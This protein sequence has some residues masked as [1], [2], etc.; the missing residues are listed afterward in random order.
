M[1]GDGIKD[2]INKERGSVVAAG[3]R[4]RFAY[5]E[6]GVYQGLLEGVAV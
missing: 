6:T 3:I 5:Y 1:A 2:N 4:I